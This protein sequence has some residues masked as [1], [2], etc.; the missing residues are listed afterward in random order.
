MA[1]T[2]YPL[3]LSG[4]HPDNRVAQ[5]PHTI[6]QPADTILVLNCGPFFAKTVIVEQ[7]SDRTKL[8]A[9]KDFT[10]NYL[11]ED[12]TQRSGKPVY[13]LIILKDKDFKGNLLVT[14]QVVGGEYADYAHAIDQALEDM[15]N[16]ESAVSWE[17]ILN[18][19]LFYPPAPH[20][21]TMDDLTGVDGIVSALN[22]IAGAIDGQRPS[23]LT[24]IYEAIRQMVTN[25]G[26]CK[27]APLSDCWL[28]TP[29]Q[30]LRLKLTGYPSTFAVLLDVFD[31]D[32]GASLLWLSGRLSL[33]GAWSFRH[34]YVLYGDRPELSCYLYNR[35]AISADV[36]FKAL[37]GSQQTLWLH[38]VVYYEMVP[39]NFQAEMIALEESFCP[40]DSHFVKLTYPWGI[41]SDLDNDRLDRLQQDLADLRIQVDNLS[42]VEGDYYPASGGPLS[43]TLTFNGE[44]RIEWQRNLS[45]AQVAFQAQSE[46]ASKSSLCFQVGGDTQEAFS[47]RMM[48]Q[49]GT[50]NEL[51]YLDNN[52]LLLAG[53]F[54]CQG[55]V[56]ANYSDD[57]LKQNILPIQNA[58]SVVTH[59]RAV[60][61][62]ANI[63]AQALG[64]YDPST[65][66]I[67]L[68]A[69]EVGHDVPEAVC[70]APFDRKSASDSKVSR[71]G[72]YYLTIKY[73]KLIP[74]LVAAIQE[75]KARV[76]ELTGAK[77][78]DGNQ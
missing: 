76:D 17:S 53:D 35:D 8:N 9:E 34:Y 72:E 15:L 74:H 44:H 66:D 39:S 22:E 65:P 64:G 56:V 70:L 21:H 49:G 6:E 31:S 50:A 16:T 28:L 58:L 78:D 43:G 73:Y 59:W 67:G 20:Q 71:S 24:A 10:F 63:K 25:T 36:L 60:R 38:S 77:N 12:A 5:E 47:W 68:I 61:Y 48:G 51:M 52:H 29:D 55:D 18:K 14:Y 13:G 40:D 62:T 75:L 69:Q 41:G 33:E 11:H 2:K 30:P 46:D 7:A 1:L 45:T 37:P 3:D 23:D 42:Q 32:A 57:R 26:H 4:C 19:P 27:R 54:H